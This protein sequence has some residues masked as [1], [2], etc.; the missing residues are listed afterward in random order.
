MKQRIAVDPGE[1][2][3]AREDH[4]AEHLHYLDLDTGE[5][6]PDHEDVAVGPRCLEVP[7]PEP[8]EGYR[9][10]ADFI[11]TVADVTTRAMLSVAIRGPGAFRRFKDVL[12]EFPG[13]RERWFGFK[14]ARTRGRLEEWLADEDVEVEW[15][16]AP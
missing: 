16:E 5:V 14:D 3:W 13:E 15:V 9:D 2:S 12:L 7:K 11:D 8:G 4:H 6:L 10:M 1:L